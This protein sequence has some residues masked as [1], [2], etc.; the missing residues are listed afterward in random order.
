MEYRE[1]E[2]KRESG[3]QEEGG[4]EERQST[5][6]EWGRDKAEY[7]DKEGKRG[8]NTG[9]ENG[10]GW[11]TGR[12]NGRGY[13]AGKGKG[14]EGGV[15]GEGREKRVEYRERIGKRANNREK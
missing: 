4:E 7:R 1:K 12:G 11:S 2:G 3:L 6:R 15:H 9:R 8:C 13:S 5:V 14:R 10:R